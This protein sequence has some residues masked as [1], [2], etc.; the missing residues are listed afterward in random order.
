VKPDTEIS[1]DSPAA[2]ATRNKSILDKQFLR[3]IYLE[4]SELIFDACSD[5]GVSIEVGAS[6][7]VSREVF[8]GMP[9]WGTDVVALPGVDIV[10]DACCL[11]FRDGSL[12]NIVAIDTLH[13]LPDAER[14]LEESERVLCR[15][16]RLVMV[17]PWNNR[18]HGSFTRSF[19]LN[20]ST[21]VRG[22]RS[23]AMGQ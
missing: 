2:F 1:I 11:A 14:F 5:G 20:P 21:N 18:W 6:N 8:G 23:L 10:T 9:C 16:G 4:W 7:V 22:G 17:E 3:Q 15:G 13:H 19:T 12:T